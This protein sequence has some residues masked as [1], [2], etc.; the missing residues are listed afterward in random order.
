MDTIDAL[1]DGELT[2]LDARGHALGVREHTPTDVRL[3]RGQALHFRIENGVCRT[4][5]ESTRLFGKR[6]SPYSW[7]GIMNR[8]TSDHVRIEIVNDASR[9]LAHAFASAIDLSNGM[10]RPLSLCADS[11]PHRAILEYRNCPPRTLLRVHWPLEP[12]GGC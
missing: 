12:R 3:V 9:G 5:D 6:W 1:E 2:L 8:Y 10:E 7:M 4:I 11:T